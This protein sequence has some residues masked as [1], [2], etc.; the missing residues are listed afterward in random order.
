MAAE[1]DVMDP[2]LP[3]CFRFLCLR[4]LFGLN[5]ACGKGKQARFSRACAK[6]LHLAIFALNFEYLEISKPL[7][8][9]QFLWR[10]PAVHHI[11][12]YGRLLGFIKASA[13]SENIS[14][15]GCGRKSCQILARLNDLAGVL[16]KLYRC[17]SC[18]GIWWWHRWLES[19]LEE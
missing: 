2:P 14:F 3:L 11:K 19:G 13:T 16:T 1:V 7:G 15:L 6:L 9:L 8:A 5:S 17:F 4:W 12:V 18:Y 10:P